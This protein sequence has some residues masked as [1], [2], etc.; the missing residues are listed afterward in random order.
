[1]S[2]RT[3][4]PVS[5]WSTRSTPAPPVSRRCCTRWPTSSPPPS[6][7]TVSTGA[8]SAITQRWSRPSTPVSGTS[9]AEH[10]GEQ[11]LR[12]RA[13]PEVAHAAG[14]EEFLRSGGV[15]KLPQL[16]LDVPRRPVDRRGQGLL[17]AASLPGRG[18][19]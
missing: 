5:S 18:F 13:S 10:P 6:P 17:H 4:P 2:E 11:P 14:D 1:T 19:R 15:E 3:P 12:L 9:S 8:R 7:A 16:H